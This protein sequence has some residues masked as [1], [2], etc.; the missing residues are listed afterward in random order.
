MEVALFSVEGV[1]W[2]S[3]GTVSMKRVLA[4][5]V[6]AWAD[7]GSVTVTILPA[8]VICIFAVDS[9]TLEVAST[10]ILSTLALGVASAVAIRLEEAV[11]TMAGRPPPV[12][13]FCVFLVVSAASEVA[14]TVE[15]STIALELA[16]EVGVRLEEG[17]VLIT[18]SPP[19]V[20]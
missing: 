5:T 11:V 20:A 19:P 8:C 17:A 13:I 2:A 1:V 6:V 14:S 16:S 15:E 7:E 3:F 12:C 4:S 10:L 18:A 9:K